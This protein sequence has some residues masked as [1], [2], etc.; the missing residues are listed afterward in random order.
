MPTE[1]TLRARLLRRVVRLTLRPI[2]ARPDLSVAQRRR[3]LLQLTPLTNALLPR[4]VR[5]EAGVLG[6][7]ATEWVRPAA[8]DGGALLYLHG[9]AYLLGS[10]RVFRPLTAGLARGGR[11]TVA[12]PDY[13]LAPEHPYPAA[14]D[15]A[16]ASYQALRDARPGQPI[17]LG[18]DSAGGHLVLLL[19][20]RLRDRGLPLPEAA[21]VISPWADLRCRQPAHQREAERDA[22]LVTPAL[23]DAAAQFASGQDLDSPALCPLQAELGGLPPLLIQGTDAEILADDATALAA[24]ALAAGVAV[25]HSIWPDLWHDW[26]LFTPLLPEARAALAELQGF[27]REPRP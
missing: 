7:V 10:P 9:G 23:H 27:L 6:G 11:F 24:R 25:R 18:G 19:L 4:D 3:R 21:F 15:D 26:Q 12:V 1:S 2:F 17:Y 20:L 14:L 5:I 22:V 16:L 8:D 13:R